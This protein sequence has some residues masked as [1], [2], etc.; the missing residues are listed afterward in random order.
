MDLT[1]TI[2]DKVVLADGYVELVEWRWPELIDF[3][4]SEE[5]LMLE[6]ALPP[7]A[8]D[9]SAEF[10]AL[11]PGRR[12]FMG[13][14]SVRYPGVVIDGRGGGGQIRVL[15]MVFAST[16]AAAILPKSGVPPLSVLQGL[17]DIRSD[18]LRKLMG[19]ALR[20]LTIR[21]D[22]S[23]EAIDA[24][25]RLIGIEVRRLLERQLHAEAGGRLASWQ[26]RRIRDRLTRGGPPPKVADLAVLCGIS[27]RHLGRQ[28]QALTGSTL[29]A[30]VENFWIERAKALLLAD[31]API[32]NIAF[33]TGFA[34]PNSFARAFRRATGLSPK[35]FRQRMAGG[36]SISTVTAG[37]SAASAWLEPHS[38]ELSRVHRSVSPRSDAPC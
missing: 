16:A 8:T 32:K 11:E 30:Y 9:A 31:D 24:L 28:F 37:D 33:A 23:L 27:V 21:E 7:Y 1:P 36:G 25:H 3:R 17:L 2:L 20:E 29:A 34:H 19:L 22:R 18:S 13:T 14:L 35:R 26:Y 12:S 38:G 5:N 10:P 4:L 15:R 6:M